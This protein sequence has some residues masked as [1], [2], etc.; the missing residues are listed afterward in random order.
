MPYRH[1]TLTERE[2]IANLHFAGH[3]PA[4][5]GRRLKRAAS[6]ISRELRRNST[7][8]R[9]R[10][11]VAH[12]SSLSRRSQRRLPRKLDHSPL[13]SEV[14]RMLSCSWSPDQVSGRLSREHPEDRRMHVSHQTI[15]RWLWSDAAIFEQFAQDLRH[16]RYRRR[17]RSGRTLIRNRVSIRQRPSVIDARS[18]VGDWEGDTIVGRGH[19][20]YVATFVDR[21]TGYLVASRMRDKRSVSLNRAAERAFRTI[22]QTA[23]HSVTVHNGTEFAQHESLTRRLKLDVY[24]AD[25]YCSWQRGTNENTNGLLRQFLPKNQELF[26]LPPTVLEFHVSRLNNRPRKRLGYLTPAEVF[27]HQLKQKQ[28]CT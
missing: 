18:R 26:D 28:R 21:M 19:Q 15:Y 6:T 13:R 14:Q 17:K 27:Q 20:G 10:A 23:R 25:A 9:Y 8:G 7:D 3:G 12:Q 24:F 5:I 22:P 1:L 4:E 11:S 16:G 2:T